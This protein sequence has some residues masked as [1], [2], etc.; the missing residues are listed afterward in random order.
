MK[1]F[2]KRPAPQSLTDWLTKYDTALRQRYEDSTKE[3]KAIWE[4]LGNALDEM[5]LSDSESDVAKQLKEQINI[6]LDQ[7]L[8]AEQGS[9]CCYC[10]KR[11][12]ENNVFVREHFKDKSGNQESVF[13]YENL[14][15]AC[16]GG[17]VT[18]FSIGQSVQLAQEII[19]INSI[20]DVVKILRHYRQKVIVEDVQNHPKNKNR[21]FGKGDKIYF[22]NPPHCDTAKGNK[23]DEIV[24]PSM[25]KDCEYWFY[26]LSDAL[27]NVRVEAYEG[28]QKDLVEKTISLLNLDER[29]LITN[30]FRRLAYDKGQQKVDALQPI[31][32]AAETNEE[33]KDILKNIIE[34]DIYAKKEGK[35]EPFCF[36]TASIL[37]NAFF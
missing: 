11:I 24:N 6:E 16:E 7:S 27:L 1:Y 37:W 10:G 28:I 31:I 8:L 29:P 9:I 23:S 12:P 32:D 30:R 36:V 33:R 18:S 35:L 22:P 21:T 25:Q 14:F 3:I 20:A 19:Q 13:N 2:K 34:E 5:M 17:K 15:A 26:Y 4:E